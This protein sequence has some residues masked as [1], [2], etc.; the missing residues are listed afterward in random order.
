MNIVETPHAPAAIGPYSQAVRAGQLLFVS[1]QLP[2]DPATGQMASTSIEGQTTQ[3]LANLSAI[4]E[5]AGLTLAHVVRTDIFLKDLQDFPQ[6][7]R[8]YGEHFTHPVKPARQ[9][10]QVAR[11]P[12]DAL[13]EIS[14]IAWLA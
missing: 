6:V 8:I 7:N 10:V 14:C 11:L 13:I 2:I 3:V 1:G 4:L 12:M 5:A 9:T